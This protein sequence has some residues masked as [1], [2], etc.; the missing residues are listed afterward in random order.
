MRIGVDVGGT[1][2]DAVLLDGEAIV[3]ACKELTSADVISGV[4]A[5]LKTLD[6]KAGGLPDLDAVMIGTSQFTNA[7]VERRELAKVAAIR[8]GL[9]SGRGLP[10][11]VGWPQDINAALGGHSHALPGGLL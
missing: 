8:I 9:P 5:A 6:D 1:H 2:T 3:A 10:P 7:V 4:K 11:G